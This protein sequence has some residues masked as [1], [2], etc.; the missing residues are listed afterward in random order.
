[1]G[2]LG[3]EGVLH[4]VDGEV[5]GGLQ[6]GEEPPLLY[7][8]RVK[9]KIVWSPFDTETRV[10]R[11]SWGVVGGRGVGTKRVTCAWR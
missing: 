6:A 5:P 2:G 1:M 3:A 4:E 11:G 8:R 7:E 10:Q 9:L